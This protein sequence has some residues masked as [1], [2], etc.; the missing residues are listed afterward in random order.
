MIS[1]HRTFCAGYVSGLFTTVPSRPASVYSAGE[2]WPLA[3]WL[4]TLPKR[5]EERTY[6]TTTFWRRFWFP[7]SGHE[8]RPNLPRDDDQPVLSDPTRKIL[9]S[10]PLRRRSK[11]WA[12]PSKRSPKWNGMKTRTSI[13]RNNDKSWMLNRSLMS[14]Y[15]QTLQ[16]KTFTRSWFVMNSPI[17]SISRPVQTWKFR[18]TLPPIWRIPHPNDKT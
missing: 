7:A 5:H 18:L 4:R 8:Q 16:K 15:I 11:T 2:S 12:N 17:V 1:E 3:D 9:T 14:H 10:R 6:D 13:L